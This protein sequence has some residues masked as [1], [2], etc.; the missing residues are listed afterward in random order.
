LIDTHPDANGIAMSNHTNIIHRGIAGLE[1][2]PP[3]YRVGPRHA[4]GA[5]RAL[6]LEEVQQ[7][8]DQTQGEDRQT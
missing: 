6:R 4:T 8:S 5:L 3:F 2:E 1:N 7:Q